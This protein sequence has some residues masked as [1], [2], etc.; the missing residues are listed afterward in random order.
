MKA[1]E[2]KVISVNPS[3]GVR[4]VRTTII[5]TTMPNTLPTNGSGITGLLPT[6]IFAPGSVIICPND[7]SKAMTNENGVFKKKA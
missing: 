3:T 5:G 4:T 6:D 1:I 2:T 7:W